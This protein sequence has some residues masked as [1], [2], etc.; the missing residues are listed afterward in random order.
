MIWAL[1]DGESPEAIELRRIDDDD[2][3]AH[4]NARTLAD[5]AWS[6]LVLHALEVDTESPECAPHRLEANASTHA[7]VS[8]EIVG[9]SAVF[10]PLSRPGPDGSRIYTSLG[11]GVF[12]W[13]D[14]S[15]TGMFEYSSRVD[16]EGEAG[17]SED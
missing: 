15:A 13:G 5:G 10:V 16:A 14:R 8:I 3:V 7:G 17:D 4:Q 9:S 11:F 12:R 1:C 6:P 2:G